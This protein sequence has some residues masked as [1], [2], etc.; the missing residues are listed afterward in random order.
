MRNFVFAAAFGA[1]VAFTTQSQASDLPFELSKSSCEYSANGLTQKCI[2]SNTLVSGADAAKLFEGEDL[3]NFTQLC[4][5][6]VSK[7]IKG[8]KQVDSVC[9][10]HY[11]FAGSNFSGSTRSGASTSSS[12]GLSQSFSASNAR[13]LSATN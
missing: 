11:I 7:N 3:V 6:S 9:L 12:K 4:K 5:S 2:A 13:S 1:L 10:N 8:D